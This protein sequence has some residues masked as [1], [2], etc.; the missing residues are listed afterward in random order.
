M[1][2][3][4][5]VRK[6]RQRKGLTQAAL[7]SAVEVHTRTVRLWEAG[8]T[9]PR[10]P[11][12]ARLEALIGRRGESAGDELPSGEWIDLL[13][14]G[15]RLPFPAGVIEAPAEAELRA[16]P[17]RGRGPRGMAMAVVDISD[18]GLAALLDRAQG[19]VVVADGDAW[20]LGDLSAGRVFRRSGGSLTSTLPDDARVH[21]VVAVFEG[22]A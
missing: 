14:G 2:V 5:W 15:G 22:V 1:E 20:V 17:A 12:M 9:T 10:H 8:E 3:G 7:A 11:V 18:A 21:P 6:G 19:R 13:S 16:V 4:E